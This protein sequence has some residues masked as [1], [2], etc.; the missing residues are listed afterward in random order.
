MEVGSACGAVI[1]ERLLV[2]GPFDPF[3]RLGERGGL[4]RI[5]GS[6]GSLWI[7]RTE[8]TERTEG[9]SQGSERRG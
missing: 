5:L 4:S 7:Q 3:G 2:V 9:E 8:F 6:V 1:G